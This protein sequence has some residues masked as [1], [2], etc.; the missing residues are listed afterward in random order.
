M[1]ISSESELLGDSEFESDSAEEQLVVQQKSE[2]TKKPS[3]KGIR[4]F[5]SSIKAALQKE[6]PEAKAAQLN[7][8]IR[9]RWEELSDLERKGILF[10]NS[11]EFQ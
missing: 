7:K 3:N 10:F 1:T 5:T 4:K 8:M 2:K 9:R 6:Y 11:T